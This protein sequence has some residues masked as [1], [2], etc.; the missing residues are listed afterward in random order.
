MSS[1]KIIRDCAEF[2]CRHLT[3]SDL[4]EVT[5]SHSGSFIPLDNSSFAAV[6]V[7]VPNEQVADVPASEELGDNKIQ[8][9]EPQQTRDECHAAYEQGRQSAIDEI[10]GKLA[11]ATRSLAAACS[12]ITSLK[13]K[14]LQRSSDDMLRL[15]FVIAERVIN[16]EISIDREIV[17]RTVQQAIQ[18]A[19]SAEEFRI[20]VNPEDMQVVQE[21]KPL[22]I[23]S[24]SGLSNIEFVAD[25]SITS[26]GCIL[27]SPLGRVD[28]TIEAQLDAIT[29]TLRQAI[30][31]DD[32]RS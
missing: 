32:D 31:T 26:G 20:K 30:G 4:D 7:A 13:E 9:N 14:M 3:L 15:V 12:E 23:A 18:A 10:E 5:E 8:Q 29:Y 2:E 1:S 6:G 24:L 21:R 25:P 28:A 19:V 11:S 17:A 27:E 16:T 22:F